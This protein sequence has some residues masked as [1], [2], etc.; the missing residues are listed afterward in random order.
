MPVRRIPIGRRSLTGAHNWD[1]RAL[2]VTFES[3][4]ERDFITLMLFE[5]TVA[6]IEE[7]PVK[8]RFS[9]DDASRRYIPDFLV[10][11]TNQASRLIEIKFSEELR[12]KAEELVPKFDAA[13]S[14]AAERGW[15]FEVWS[16]LEIR[17]TRLANAKF[18]LPFNRYEPDAG[19]AARLLRFFQTSQASFASTEEALR[20]CWDDEAE[21]ARGLHTLWTLVARRRLVTD[22][23]QP[24]TANSYLRLA[25]GDA[26]A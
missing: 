20:A 17:T 11:F 8:I 2:G 12:S 10:D 13:E 1:P 18:L 9:H 4:L 22:F 24:L 21:R 25:G 5:P 19:L 23:D 14:Y 7:Q 3:S 16:E 26:Y 15:L 6:S